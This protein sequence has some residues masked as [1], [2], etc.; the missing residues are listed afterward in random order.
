MDEQK[1]NKQNIIIESI[2]KTLNKNHNALN[3]KMENQLNDKQLNK[4][5]YR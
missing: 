1:E 2:L 4:N 5:F 3:D